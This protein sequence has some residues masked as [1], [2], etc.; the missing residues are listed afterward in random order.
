LAQIF[1]GDPPQWAP[2]VIETLYKDPDFI[3]AGFH[4]GWFTT[5]A[6]NTK[7]ECTITEALK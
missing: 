4:I 5:S 6:V 7:E 3:K 2:R 1:P